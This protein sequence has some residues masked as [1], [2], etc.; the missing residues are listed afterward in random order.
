MPTAAPAL[1]ARAMASDNCFL[2]NFI[3]SPQRWMIHQTETPLASPGCAHAI[4]RAQSSRDIN[5]ASKSAAMKTRRRESVA[6]E[7]VAILLPLPA[8]PAQPDDLFDVVAA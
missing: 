7:V 3:M 2:F 1:T 6:G 5:P 4:A 8:S